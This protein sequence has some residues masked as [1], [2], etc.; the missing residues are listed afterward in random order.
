MHVEWAATPV[1]TPAVIVNTT[2]ADAHVM[3]LFRIS[4]SS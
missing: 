1:A 3:T 2:T 4:E